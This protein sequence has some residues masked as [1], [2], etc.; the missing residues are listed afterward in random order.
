MEP[1]AETVADRMSILVVL[2][3]SQNFVWM[4]P[5][6]GNSRIL[7]YKKT[8]S[9]TEAMSQRTSHLPLHAG[10]LENSELIARYDDAIVRAQWRKTNQSRP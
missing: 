1:T 3:N 7:S 5:L 10:R 9:W 8:R 4:H 6:Q 2:A